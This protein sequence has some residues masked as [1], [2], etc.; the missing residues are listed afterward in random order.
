MK[1]FSA[2]KHVRGGKWGSFESPSLATKCGAGNATL[3]QGGP[4]G[5]YGEG[6]L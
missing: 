3:D 4:G 6:G 5:I 2:E 1:A